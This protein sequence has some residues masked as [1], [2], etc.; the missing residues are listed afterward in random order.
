MEHFF[1]FFIHLERGRAWI[2]LRVTASKKL[3][4]IIIIFAHFTQ[5]WKVH[6][7]K[8]IQWV[9]ILLLTYH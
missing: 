8:K 9:N 2:K 1:F 3:A 4:F 5:K 6:K 7:R